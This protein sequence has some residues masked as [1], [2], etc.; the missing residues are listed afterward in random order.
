MWSLGA[1]AERRIPRISWRR[2]GAVS[3]FAPWSCISYSEKPAP[4]MA[5]CESWGAGRVSVM[6]S[7]PEPLSPKAKAFHAH[8]DV[9]VRCE[10][11][12]FDLCATGARL[13][14]EAALESAAALGIADA[15]KRCFDAAEGP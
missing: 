10:N 11:A 12:P 1:L 3:N 9:C 2:A 13:I 14:R 8:L 7:N 5:F 6:P 15:A 4:L